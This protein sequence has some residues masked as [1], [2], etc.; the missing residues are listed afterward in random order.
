[1]LNVKMKTPWIIFG[2]K[3]PLVCLYSIHTV[4][5]LSNFSVPQILREF[6]FGDSTCTNLAILR[7]LEALTFVF[8]GFFQ[9]L[10]AEICQLTKFCVPKI[11]KKGRFKTSTFT[12]M[13]FT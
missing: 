2:K 8:N 10:K 3:E 7:H 5:K 12:K 9:F 13:D 11:A 4:W 6:N 1:M